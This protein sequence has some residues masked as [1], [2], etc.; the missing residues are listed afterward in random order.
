MSKISRKIVIGSTAGFVL[1]HFAFA[2]LS[3]IED[4]LDYLI[5]AATPLLSILVG[6]A[7]VVFFWGIVKT[8]AHGGDETARAEGKEL[9]VWGMVGFVVMV[10]FWAILGFI[11]ES[12]YASAGGSPTPISSLELQRQTIPTI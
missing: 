3:T 10:S 9:M 6:I 2:A 5:S 11:Q 1:P 8:I 4:V 7:I 12:F